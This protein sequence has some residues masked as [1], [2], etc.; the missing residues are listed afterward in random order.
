M[1]TF[2]FESILLFKPTALAFHLPFYA[3]IKGLIYCSCCVGKH[4]IIHLKFEMNS[5]I[6]VNCSGQFRKLYIFITK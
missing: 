3:V 5:S 2:I 1:V 6:V 4:Y